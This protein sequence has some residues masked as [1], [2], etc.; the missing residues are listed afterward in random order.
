MNRKLTRRILAFYQLLRVSRKTQR[1]NI[2]KGSGFKQFGY[3]VTTQRA[4]MQKRSGI[5]IFI[6]FTYCIV[7]YTEQ[8]K[9]H[10]QSA[11]VWGCLIQRWKNY[12]QTPIILSN[13]KTKQT[14]SY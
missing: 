2:G 7:N 10:K 1:E 13:I 11:S 12:H 14:A 6:F 8:P 5:E 3:S 9:N 4:Y